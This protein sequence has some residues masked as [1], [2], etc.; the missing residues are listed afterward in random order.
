MKSWGESR[1]SIVLASFAPVGAGGIVIREGEIDW[2]DAWSTFVTGLS[3]KARLGAWL[4]LLIA[5]SAPLWAYGQLASLARL[6]WDA[7]A[8]A[9]SVL[10]EHRLYLVRELVLMLKV[11][12][13]MAMF[14]SSEL[15]ARTGYDRPERPGRLAVLR[16][17]SSS[18][19]EA[20]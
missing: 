11:C 5:W 2:A 20:A 8:R 17:S 4:G 19:S 10:L 6:G 12:A 16:T 13:C 18:S 9:M 14:R 7:R 1:A 15:R 3:A